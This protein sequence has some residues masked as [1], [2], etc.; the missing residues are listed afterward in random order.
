L[1]GNCQRSQNYVSLHLERLFYS[2]KYYWDKSQ[3]KKRLL[4]LT[5]QR[6]KIT[7]M[8]I[9]GREYDFLDFK[10]VVKIY[11]NCLGKN[12]GEKIFCIEFSASKNCGLR[13][14]KVQ[15]LR[16]FMK[17]KSKHQH[18]VN[19]MWLKVPHHA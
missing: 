8:T 15:G 6:K 12:I 4:P 13:A 3:K 9:S 5:L 17:Q 18:F 19:Q 11:S 16:K 1:Q 14:I 10:M 2:L 7:K